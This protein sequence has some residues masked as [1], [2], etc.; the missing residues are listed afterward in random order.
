MSGTKAPPGAVTAPLLLALSLLALSL[1]APSP[2]APW[3]LAPLLLAL[4]V[5]AQSTLPEPKL[6]GMASMAEATCLLS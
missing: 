5:S 4:S 2:L 6:D 1:L 3:L